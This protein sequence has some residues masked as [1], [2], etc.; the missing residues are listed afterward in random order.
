VG[1]PAPAD[2]MSA[3]VMR[4]DITKLFDGERLG[5]QIFEQLARIIDGFGESEIRVTRSQV[6]FRHV[7]TFA[8]VWRPSMYVSSNVPVVLSIAAPTRLRS[9]RFKQVVHPAPTTWM[10]HLELRDLC[11]IDEE[12]REWLADAWRSAGEDHA[13]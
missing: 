4:P 3:V 12:V 6:S 13:S 2:D 5:L 8:L 1:K 9:S 10:H 7:K 11:D